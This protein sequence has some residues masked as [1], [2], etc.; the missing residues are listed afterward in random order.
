MHV[1]ADNLARSLSELSA[2]SDE[3]GQ[4]PDVVARVVDGASALLGVTGVGLMLTDPDTGGLHYV[5]AT[6]DDARELEIAHESVGE[7]PCIDTY[8][9]SRSIRTDDIQNDDRWPALRAALGATGIRAVMGVPVRIDDNTI[10][11]LN[12]YARK[13]KLWDDS[14]TDA[15][16]AYGHLLEARMK[17]TLL[18]HENSRQSEL[19]A[20]LQTALDQRVRIERAVGLLMEREQTTAAIAFNMLR[21]YARSSRRRV[22]DIA[23]EL[24][25]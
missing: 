4:L 25:A 16:S 8:V 15:L 14:E 13:P 3:E 17:A 2:L 19:V 21:A 24:I 12:A 7:G 18:A 5:A 6:D 9:S 11:S 20:Q 10:G 23:D 1:D 22:L